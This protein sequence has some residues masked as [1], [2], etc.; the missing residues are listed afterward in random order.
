MVWPVGNNHGMCSST[1][2]RFT[3]DDRPRIKYIDSRA[4]GVAPD[5]DDMVEPWLDS[6]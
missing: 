5:P 3:S 4:F 2:R 6:Y 1:V